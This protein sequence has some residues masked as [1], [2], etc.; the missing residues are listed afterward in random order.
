MSKVMNSLYEEGKNVAKQQIM[1]F[2]QEGTRVSIIQ[3]SAM[4]DLSYSVTKKCLE[5]LVSN[6]PQE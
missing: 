2:I 6:Y 4:V 3:V 5:E 1:S